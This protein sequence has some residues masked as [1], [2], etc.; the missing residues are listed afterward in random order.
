MR[1]LKPPRALSREF[2]EAEIRAMDAKW[3]RLARYDSAV[4][5]M[6]DGTSAALYRR[7]PAQFRELMRRTVEIHERSGASGRGWPRST[8]PSSAEITSPEA[9]D[10]TFRPWTE[11]DARTTDDWPH[12]ADGRDVA[13]TQR[14]VDAPLASPAADSGLLEVFRRRYLLRLLVRRE[15]SAR[16]QGSFLGLLWSYI[17]PLS[18]VLHLLRS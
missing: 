1:Q 15:I 10:E 18:P 11:L 5:S 4:V 7:D 6:T 13:P 17:N 16:Y 2:P 3:Y 9:W 14:L 12:R 8:A